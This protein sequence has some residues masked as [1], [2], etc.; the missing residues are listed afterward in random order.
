MP[1]SIDLTG[2]A[3]VVVALW[4]LTVIFRVMSRWHL[5]LVFRRVLLTAVA[6]AIVVFCWNLWQSWR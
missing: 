1:G 4:I 2:L 3:V 6:V 5:Y